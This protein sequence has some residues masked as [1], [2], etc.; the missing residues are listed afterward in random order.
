M[1]G[2]VMDVQSHDEG[3]GGGSVTVVHISV[4]GIQNRSI[5]EGVEK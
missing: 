4:T 1:V 3:K 2:S 5:T